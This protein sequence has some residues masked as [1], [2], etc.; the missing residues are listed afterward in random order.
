[1]EAVSME[2][3]SY[4]VGVD[5]GVVP[6]QPVIQDGDDHSSSCDAFLPHRDH[7]QVQ[8]WQWGRRPRILLEEK[9]RGNLL[10][11]TTN[12][13]RVM[14]TNPVCC[15]LWL[16]FRITKL[17]VNLN[18]NEQFVQQALMCEKKLSGR[19]LLH[20]PV[21]PMTF[22]FIT[23][24]LA[25]PLSELRSTPAV[26]PLVGRPLPVRHNYTGFCVVHYSHST[27]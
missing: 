11:M 19:R 27:D 5:V 26:R 20:L 12:A 10:S 9:C 6:L 21:L 18:W 25:F 2:T 1:M 4:V 14:K 7:M 24:L 15:L 16:F 17:H 8:L 13:S 23:G 3:V 22:K